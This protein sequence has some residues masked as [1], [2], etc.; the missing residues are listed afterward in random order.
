MDRF[1]YV[2]MSGAKETL[3][4]QTANNHNLANASTTGFRADLSAFQSTCRR[5]LGLRVAR[6]CDQLD[7]GLGSDAGRA[8]VDRSRSG[9]RHQRRGLD[10][11]AGHRTAARL[12]RAPA[13]CASMP[14][15]MLLTGAGRQV[16]GDGGPIS[17][18]PNTSLLSAATAPSRSFRSGPGPGNR[19]DGRSHQAGESAGRDDRARRRRLV[20]RM[21]RRQPSAAAMRA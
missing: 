5:R 10:R 9:C 19:G 17:V 1:L 13:I 16:L 12:T 2:A 14:N 6:L 21:I 11:G 7:H 3:R 4:A 20:S 15:G 8:D 18:P